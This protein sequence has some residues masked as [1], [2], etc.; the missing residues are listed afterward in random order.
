MAVMI[1]GILFY[2]ITEAVTKRVAGLLG[3]KGL[4]Y[5]LQQLPMFLVLFIGTGSAY[6]HIMLAPIAEVIIKFVLLYSAVGI[7]F[8]LFLALIRQLHYQSY[9]FILNWLRRD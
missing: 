8:L 9:I 4:P 5:E 6:K 3:K 1:G 7:V 2:L